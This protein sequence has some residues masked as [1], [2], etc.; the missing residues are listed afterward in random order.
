[1]L[2][3]KVVKTRKKDTI[4]EVISPIIA[5]KD[6]IIRDDLKDIVLILENKG[7]VDTHSLELVLDFG[8]NTV[9]L[10]LAYFR[11]KATV[12]D[13]VNNEYKAELDFTEKLKAALPDEQAFCEMILFQDHHNLANLESEVLISR[14]SDRQDIGLNAKGKATPILM[15][16]AN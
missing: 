8:I 6:I 12:K 3:K 15:S 9:E 13:L 5:I 4:F 11:I 10:R 7:L 16:I 2:P 14:S 1:M